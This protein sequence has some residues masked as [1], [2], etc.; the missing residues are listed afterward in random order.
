M[1][2]SEVNHQ[3][4]LQMRKVLNHGRRSKKV[5]SNI[6]DLIFHVSFFISPSGIT[7]LRFKTIVSGET[8]KLF[9][10][11][12]FL[13]IASCLDHCRRK[14]VQSQFPW[15]KT[16]LFKKVFQSFQETLSV[17]CG[18]WSNETRITVRKT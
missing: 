15:N 6:S 13:S 4:F 12:C 5:I 1:V 11:D 9:G 8:L 17:F 10:K 7:C 18:Q 2:F 3:Q 16:Y 14:I